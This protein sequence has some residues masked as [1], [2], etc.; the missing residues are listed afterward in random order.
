MLFNDV[1]VG[2]IIFCLTSFLNSYIKMT[3][4]VKFFYLKNFKSA[5]PLIGHH[6]Y[7]FLT[8]ISHLG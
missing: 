2:F 5:M 6:F 7:R 1:F 8:Y 3:V 4:S